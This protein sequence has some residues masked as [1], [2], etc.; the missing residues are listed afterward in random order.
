VVA[1]G[2]AVSPSATLAVDAKAKALQAA[3]EQVI[4]FGAG[5]PDFPTPTEICEAA[6]AA[7]L[8]PKNHRYSR[9]APPELREAIVARPARHRY[10]VTANRS[11]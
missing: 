11:S 8:E 1:A 3:G 9:R 6:A 2:S 4:G 5:E 7:C 10:G